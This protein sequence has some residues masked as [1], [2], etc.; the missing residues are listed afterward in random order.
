M[1]YVA[2]GVLLLIVFIIAA[3]LYVN[4]P[5]QTLLQVLKWTAV[6]FVVLLGGYLAVTGRLGWALFAAPALYPLYQRLRQAMR[7]SKT[8]TRMN[9]AN[10]GGLGTGQTSEVRTRFV[11]MVLDH[12]TGEMNGDVLTGRFAGKTL[13]NLPLENLLALLAEARDDDDSVQVLTAYLERYHG[14]VWRERAAGAG[15]G[16]GA[17]SPS[18]TMTREEAY[19]ILGLDSGADAAAVKAAHH[20]LMSKIHPDHGGSTYLA[21]KINQAKDL[22]LH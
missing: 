20:R 8:F 10:D 15:T 5:P 14:D 12:D 18:S 9:Q 3:R 4:A 6:T 19:A 16:Q 2:L 21:A 13:R 1:P 22:L 11:R 17:S 7:M